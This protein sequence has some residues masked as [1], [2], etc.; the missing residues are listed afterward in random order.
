MTA[1]S[2]WLQVCAVALL[3]CVMPPRAL[4]RLLLLAVLL[5]PLAVFAA[6]SNDID[7]S[8]IKTLQ[9]TDIMT[10]HDWGKA[11]GA[12]R[13]LCFTMDSRTWIC[14][15]GDYVACIDYSCFVIGACGYG[16]DGNGK[17]LAPTDERT[18]HV[19]TV[20]NGG[21]VSLIKGLTKHEAEIMQKKLELYCQQNSLCDL[22]PG[23]VVRVE[24]FE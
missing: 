16:T 19:L 18:W 5:A 17:S 1:L 2:A 6:E 10:C 8:M 24:V 22:T 7:P 4:W 14:D 12:E 11:R 15:T 20:S 13:R 23:T 3:I 21:T 9:A